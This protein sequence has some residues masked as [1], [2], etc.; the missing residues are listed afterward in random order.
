LF[1]LEAMKMET[2]IA[3]PAEGQVVKVEVAIGDSVAA[4][5]TLAIVE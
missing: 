2:T 4:G 1:V 3:A 5:Q